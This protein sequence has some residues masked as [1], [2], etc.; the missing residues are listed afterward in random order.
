[1][2]NTTSCCPVCLEILPAVKKVEGN[3][4]YLERNCPKHGFFKTLVSKDAERFFDKRFISAGK[5][6]YENQTEVAKGCPYDCGLCPEHKQHLCSALIEITDK[7]NLSCP[8]CYFGECGGSDISL[9]EFK[10]RLATVMRTEN[11]KLDVLQVSGGEPTLHPLF[12]EIISEACLENIGRVV[13]NTNGIKLLEDDKLFEVIKKNKERLEIYLQ[14]DGFN[15]TANLKLRGLDLSEVKTKVIAKLD[16]ED[17]RMSFAVT[18]IEDNLS[19]LKK[20]LDLACKTKNVTG[21]T[22]QR[23][24]KSG[25]GTS[26]SEEK[27]L[28]QED[29]LVAISD[30]GYLKYQDIV[31]LPCSHENC[32]SISFLFVT[33]DKIYSLADFINYEKHQNIIKDKIGFEASILD[34]IKEE[35]G[36]AC[37]SSFMTK[38]LPVVQKFREFAAG[39][40]AVNHNMKILRILVKNFMDSST[41]DTERAK[42][43]CIGVATGDNKIIPFCVN[44]IFKNKSC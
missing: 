23:L 19:E 9:A 11:G 42:K 16:S 7:C 32:T 1:M 21:I 41:F 3:L 44:N 40:K 38:A 37:C 6:R 25:K 22:F 14:F 27:A 28:V 35:F 12:E 13:I 8:V 2:Y 34:Y 15:E 36:C 20:I 30:S 31:P 5:E 10:K 29:L 4:V 17:I 18:V 33:K 26:L 24:T 39:R 43:C